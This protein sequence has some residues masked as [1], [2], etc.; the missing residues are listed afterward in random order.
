MVLGGNIAGDLNI[1]SIFQ[2]NISS[3]SQS[4]GVD[5]SNYLG[6]IGVILNCG[7]GASG[8]AVVVN[9]ATSNDTNYSN[10]I[11]VTATVPNFTN[12]ASQTVV[13]LDTRVLRKYLFV[14]YLI[15]G[16][17]TAN[18]FVDGTIVAQAKYKTS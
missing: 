10:S 6:I 9:F 13:G 17:A 2:T 15:T 8:T 1:K 18:T 3:N 12:V 11:A 14:N 4:A 7:N 5:V 16:S